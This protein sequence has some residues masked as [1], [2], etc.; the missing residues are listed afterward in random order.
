MS[1]IKRRYLAV[2]G[3]RAA[4]RGAAVAAAGCRGSGSGSKSLEQYPDDGRDGLDR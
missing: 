2:G 1:R 3:L 4:D